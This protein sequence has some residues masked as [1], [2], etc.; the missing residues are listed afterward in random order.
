[1]RISLIKK[2]L[3]RQ[4]KINDL[5]YLING[6]VSD[7][8]LDDFE[9]NSQK[10][11]RLEF[12]FKGVKPFRGRDSEKIDGPTYIFRTEN[13]FADVVTLHYCLLWLEKYHQ[14]LSTKES[15][16]DTSS[17]IKRVDLSPIPNEEVAETKG[18]ERWDEYIQ[19]IGSM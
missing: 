14:R 8:K 2:I 19:R 9:I 18:D 6:V 12:H 13:N 11:Y 10:N 7:V 3:E 4:S 1:M 5:T 17:E 15:S 16:T